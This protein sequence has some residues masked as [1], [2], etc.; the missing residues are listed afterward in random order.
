MKNKLLFL[1]SLLV[2]SATSVG[3]YAILGD[4]TPIMAAKLGAVSG[5]LGLGSVGFF[6]TGL[7]TPKTTAT[8]TVEVSKNDQNA[9]S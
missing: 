2:V 1:S 3:V 7:A 8:V 9:A 5:I 4:L 6:F